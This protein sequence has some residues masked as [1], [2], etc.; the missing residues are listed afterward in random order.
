[1]NVLRNVKFVYQ[2]ANN[3]LK[4]NTNSH[5]GKTC[6]VI[7]TRNCSNSKSSQTE[8]KALQ[9]ETSTEDCEDMFISDIEN[10]YKPKKRLCI[11]CKY[12]IPVDYKNV[13]L[14][15]QFISPYTGKIYEK[16]IT[17]LCDAQQKRVVAM[18]QVSRNLGYM[19]TFL[20]EPKYLK[21]PKL[22]DPFSPTRPNPH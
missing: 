7:L 12:K 5:V 14:L 13:R 4:L 15:S 22:F 1:M 8:E 10:P 11:L 17:G 6:S 9:K 21:D 19:G 18:I 2:A 16:H 20:K 3:I